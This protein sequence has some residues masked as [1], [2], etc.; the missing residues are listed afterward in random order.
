MERDPG[1]SNPGALYA[2][3]YDT[4]I[5]TAACSIIREAQGEPARI[6]PRYDVLGRE[7]EASHRY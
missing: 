4:M 5:V 7:A 3:D 2:Y 6:S 1:R